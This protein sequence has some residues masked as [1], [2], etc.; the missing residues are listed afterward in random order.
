[1]PIRLLISD[2]DG[3]LVTT[4]KVLTPA[5][6]EAVA[7][8]RAAGILFAVVSS[9]PPRGMAMLVGPLRIDTPMGA[10]NGGTI[11]NPDFTPVEARVVPEAAAHTAYDLF[12]QRG[13][14]TWVFADGEWLLTNPD[15]HY[16][17]RELHTVQFDYRRVDD[18]RPYLARAGKIVGTTDDFALLERVEHEL[19]GLLGHAANAHRS[20][21]YYLDVTHPEANKGTAVHAIAGHLGVAIEDVAC[22]GDM[23]NDVPMFAVAGYSICMGNGPPEV[24]A[25]ASDV[26]TGN[27]EDGF[28]AA[29]DRFVL[30]RRQ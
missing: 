4:E 9:R 13:V 18:L 17:P 6:V 22:I 30:P 8:L 15:A 2:V 21:K 28:A 29:V 12:E 27:D 10:F 16:V 26:T 23:T 11:V 19:E 7:K 1:M 24:Q 3:T 20:Q 25:R 5:S 14:D